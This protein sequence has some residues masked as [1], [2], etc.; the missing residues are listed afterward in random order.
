MIENYRQGNA[1][2][3]SLAF[4]TV[5]FIGDLANFF[6]AIWA[7]LVPTVIALAIYFCIADSVLICQVLYY[8]HVNSSKKLFVKSHFGD[9]DRPDQPLLGRRPSSDV[10]LPG[11]RRRSSVSQ[12][13][14]DSTIAALA[15]PSIPEES[16]HARELIKNTLSVL[17]VCAV[18]SIGWA[19]AW[20]AGAWKPTAQSPDED[21]TDRNV[22]AEILG[23]LSAIAYLG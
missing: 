10:G 1:E 5:W 2:G 13:R 16:G 19:I 17:A 22:G 12:K 4:L 23:Y 9:A 20:K 6:G 7:G 11:S 18:G 15:L 3:L 21:T 8:N 14:R